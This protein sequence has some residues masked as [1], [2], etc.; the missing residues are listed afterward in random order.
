MRR[1][2][3]Y[4]ENTAMRIVVSL[5]YNIGDEVEEEV[6]SECD[7]RMSSLETTNTV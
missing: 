6:I 7:D 2:D 1:Y 3:D 4:L 5:P